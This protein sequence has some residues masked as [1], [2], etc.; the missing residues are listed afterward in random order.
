MPDGQVLIVDCP[1]DKIKERSLAARGR[2]KELPYGERIVAQLQL[3][4]FLEHAT[5]TGTPCPTCN[6][7]G[8]ELRLI[9][10]GPGGPLELGV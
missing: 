1:L 6:G 4:T 8:W 2:L 9:Q 10:V 7:Q 3:E 5:Y